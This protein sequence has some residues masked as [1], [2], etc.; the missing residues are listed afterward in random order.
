MIPEANVL[1]VTMDT[2]LLQLLLPHSSQCSQHR[3][4][5]IQQGVELQVA[6]NIL[7]QWNVS[8]ANGRIKKIG[9]LNEAVL[10]VFIACY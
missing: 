8:R 5:R 3:L 1:L 6:V 2:L 10:T 9:W 7:N 4:I